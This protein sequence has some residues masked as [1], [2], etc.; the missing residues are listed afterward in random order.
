MNAEVISGFCCSRC[1]GWSC[2]ASSRSAATSPTSW[3]AGRTSLARVGGRVEALD[4][5]RICGI[6][7]ARRWPGRKYA[8]ALLLFNV[9]GALVVYGLQ[10]LQFFLPL[11]PQKFAAVQ[12]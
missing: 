5:S 1:S 6:E 12:P 8:I 9:L 4:L 7:P 3:K 2:C 10:R 11:N